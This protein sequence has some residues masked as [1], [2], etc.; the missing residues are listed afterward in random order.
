MTHGDWCIGLDKWAG[1]QRCLAFVTARDAELPY[2]VAGTWKLADNAAGWVD[3]VNV[4]VTRGEEPPPAMASEAGPSEAQTRGFIRARD[5]RPSFT[6]GPDSDI[7]GGEN[8]IKQRAVPASPVSASSAPVEAEPVAQPQPG[9]T[10]ARAAAAA[11]TRARDC[12]NHLRS[13]RTRTSRR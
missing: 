7:G 1:T 2:D 12:A 6:F 4:Q 10:A 13:A 9:Q 3:N 8:A 11:P 5:A